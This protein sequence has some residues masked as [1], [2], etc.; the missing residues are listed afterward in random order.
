MCQVSGCVS[1]VSAQRSSGKLSLEQA[2]PG[3]CPALSEWQEAG[4]ELLGTPWPAAV[5][6]WLCRHRAPADLASAAGSCASS[7]T[8]AAVTPAAVYVSA[9]SSNALCATRLEVEVA[10]EGDS[11]AALEGLAVRAQLYRCNAA[12]EV[13]PAGG[14]W[15]ACFRAGVIA[16]AAGCGRQCRGAACSLASESG[17][18]VSCFQLRSCPPCRHTLETHPRCWWRRP[19]AGCIAWFIFCPSCAC[20]LP[21]PLCRCPRGASGR[22]LVRPAPL[23]D[24]S[25]HER[26]GERR[27]G[28]CWGSGAGG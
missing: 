21:L 18:C 2:P 10:L 22:G 27:T 1:L 24:G 17:E 9:A 19:A 25:R 16:A 26:T 3:R 7:P 6:D 14:E 5:P 11:S 12:G 15:N 4:L 8:A 20:L 23:L 28:V 13:D